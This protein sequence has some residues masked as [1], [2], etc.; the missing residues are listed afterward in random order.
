MGQRFH[1]LIRGSRSEFWPLPRA[2]STKDL[3]LIRSPPQQF[4]RDLHLRDSPKLRRS[5]MFIVKQRTSPCNSVGVTCLDCLHK[6]LGNIN[7]LHATPT[8]FN[9]IQYSTCYNHITPS[10]VVRGSLMTL[11]GRQQQTEFR[12]T[13]CIAEFHLKRFLHLDIRK[14]RTRTE[15]FY[16]KYPK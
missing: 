15:I 16:Q 8:E 1:P 6:K 4:Q 11:K 14:Q 3:R 2:R 10:G 7:K 5:A 12:C 13:P 9:G